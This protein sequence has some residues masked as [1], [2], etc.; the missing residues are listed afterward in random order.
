MMKSEAITSVPIREGDSAV[1]L[2]VPLRSEE[3]LSTV[4]QSPMRTFVIVVE[5][6]IRHSR[7]I[8]PRSEATDRA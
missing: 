8:V 6:V 3:M 7:P 1:L 5:L 2:I 4:T